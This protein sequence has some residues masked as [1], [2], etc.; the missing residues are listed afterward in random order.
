MKAAKLFLSL[1]A[2]FVLIT[3]GCGHSPVS[4]N[5]EN[6]ANDATD[7]PLASPAAVM[8]KLVRAPQ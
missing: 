7:A 1:V 6:D 2:L 8:A 5:D 3:T 4:P